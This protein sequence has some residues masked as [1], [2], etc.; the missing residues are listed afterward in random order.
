MIILFIFAKTI[1]N[2]FMSIFFRI[3]IILALLVIPIFLKISLW[4]KIL[5]SFFLGLIIII[6]LIKIEFFSSPNYTSY[7][8]DVLLYLINCVAYIVFNVIS[9]LI[10]F[11]KPDNR[12][13][14]FFFF[15]TIAAFIV[16]IFTSFDALEY[17][18]LVT[19]NILLTFLPIYIYIYY[20]KYKKKI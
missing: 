1:S 14:Y 4:S 9:S 5:V 6:L 13:E 2:P 19:A 3:I 8:G 7:K 12:K 10:V 20:S 15:P 18:S 11:I 16:F 17:S